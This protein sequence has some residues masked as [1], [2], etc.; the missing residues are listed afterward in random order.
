MASKT[1]DERIKEKGQSEIVIKEFEAQQIAEE[2]VR[3]RFEKLR[4][5]EEQKAD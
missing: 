2:F 1:S 3:Q 5:E 4:I